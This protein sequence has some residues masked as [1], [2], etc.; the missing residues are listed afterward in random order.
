MR[1][2]TKVLVLAGVLVLL[3]AG[4]SLAVRQRN[5]ALSSP[6]YCTLCAIGPEATPVDREGTVTGI[7]LPRNRKDVA[8]FI[9]H[10][11]AGDIPVRTAPLSY[12]QANAVPLREGDLVHVYGWQ[13]TDGGTP[14]LVAR[15]LHIG[16]KAYTLRTP[17]GKPNY[18]GR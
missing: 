8:T 3:F 6:A 1:R 16:D 14:Y 7:A 5:L 12:L 4:I 9:L 11:P 2:T 13:L 10:S 15:Q 18:W 17:S